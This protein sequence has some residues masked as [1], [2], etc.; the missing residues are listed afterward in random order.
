M[1]AVK[2]TEV[3]F[4]LLSSTGAI[5]VAFGAIASRY[6]VLVDNVDV[7]VENATVAYNSILAR[8]AEQYNLALADVASLIQKL[9]NTIKYEGTDYNN[10][11]VTGGFF[12]L[13]GLF[14]HEKGYTLV[15]NEFI[16]AINL[17]YSS[18]VPLVNCK[19]CRGVL[20]P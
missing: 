14:P 1:L 16:K 11:V 15:A 3:L 12:S 20:F 19:D 2:F 13:D 9:T 18:S 5:K 10:T 8:K 17:K 7:S 6:I 4:V